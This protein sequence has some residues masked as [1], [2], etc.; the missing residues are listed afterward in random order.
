[1]DFTATVSRFQL[2]WVDTGPTKV[3]GDGK[4]S[5]RSSPCKI[6]ATSVFVFSHVA[7]CNKL[8][9]AVTEPHQEYIKKHRQ[10]LVT[11][12]TRKPQQDSGRYT[13]GLRTYVPGSK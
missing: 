1:M 5:G 11:N 13:D 3:L 9:P 12:P 2:R 10:V 6:F 4:E 8:Y 7:H